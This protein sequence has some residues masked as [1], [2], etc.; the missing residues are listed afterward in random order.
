MMSIETPQL[1]PRRET[2]IGIA[3]A[4]LAT[5][6]WSTNLVLARWLRED[7]GPLTLAAARFLIASALFAALLSRQPQTARK[8]GNDRWLLAGMAAAGVVAFAPTLY[9]GLHFTPAVNAAFINSFGPPITGVLAA[10]LIGEPMTRYQG[11][12]AVIGLLGVTILITGGSLALS[13]LGQINAGQ[14]IVLA[15]VSLWSLYSVLSRRVMRHRSALSATALS[16]FIGLPV[17]LVAALWELQSFPVH[18]RPAVLAAVIY[19]GISPTVIGFLAWNGGVRRLGAS[20][21]MVF[22]NTLPLFGIVLGYL[23]LG[24]RLGPS[25]LL[26]GM[27]IIGG[28]LWAARGRRREPNRST[29]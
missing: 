17:L 10:L 18:F 15:A 2:L 28:G 21:A 27:L 7:I 19:I 14:L 25:D 16:T 5:L 9:L 24:E 20:G 12:G 23:F 1:A 26:G 6:S 13:A 3:L 22:Y 29:A 4:N 8:A 11:I